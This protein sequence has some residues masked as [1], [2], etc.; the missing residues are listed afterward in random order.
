MKYFVNAESSSSGQAGF[1]IRQSEILFGTAGDEKE[2]PNP[3]ELLLG[4]FAA[5]CLKNVDRFSKILKFH[6]E[7]AQI[8]VSA[9]RQNVPSK[10]TSIHYIIQIKSGDERLNLKLLHK[11]IEKHG[12]IYNTLKAV[13]SISGDIQIV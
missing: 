9:E 12:T 11:N 10:I 3:A 5:C 13:C 6:Y 8:E 4:A 2:L 1:T 7:T